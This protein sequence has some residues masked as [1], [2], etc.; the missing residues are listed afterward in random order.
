[1]Y[2]GRKIPKSSPII[3]SNWTTDKE[4]YTVL[5]FPRRPKLMMTSVLLIFII[6]FSKERAQYAQEREKYEPVFG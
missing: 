5:L 2:A 4:R 1:M 3:T 6:Q